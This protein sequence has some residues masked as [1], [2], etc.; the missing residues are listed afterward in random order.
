M[1]KIKSKKYRKKPS[2]LITNT[3]FS[4]QI[5]VIMRHLSFLILLVVSTAIFGQSKKYGSLRDGTTGEPLNGALISCKSNVQ[6]TSDAFGN[7]F[8]SDSDCSEINIT[9]LGYEPISV[10]STRLGADANS[11]SVI[12]LNALPNQLD[13]VTVT[14]SRYE[15]S[16]TQNTISV[17]VIKPALIN[18]INSNSGDAVLNKLPGVQVVGGQANIRGGSGFSYGAGSRV[19]LLIDDMPA[20]QAD[21]GFTNWSDIPIENIGQIEVL[22]GAGS[23]LYGSAALN[24]IVNIRRASPRITPETEAS[25]GYTLFDKFPDPR[26]TWYDFQPYRVNTSLT[27]RRK[28]GK[29]DLTAHGFYNKL[30]SYA[31]ETYENRGRAGLT[32]KY[33][34]SDQWTF[35]LN[36]LLNINHSS[37]FFVWSNAL[38]G[39]LQPYP[40]TVSEGKR[41]RYMIDPFLQY[42]DDRGNQHKLQ[43]RL[44]G[45]NNDNNNNQSNSSLTKYAE[46]QYQKNFDRIGLVLTSGLMGSW[47]SSDAE[48]FGD[49]TFNFQNHAA[50]LQLEK[51]YK[52]WTWT[53]GV[54]YEYNQQ[55][56]PANFQGIEIPGGEI[57]DDQIISR[58]GFNYSL[59]EYTSIRASWGQGYRY[60]TITERFITTNFGGIPINPNPLLKPE[61]GWTAELALKQG[62]KVGLFE[63]FVDIAG[64][65]SVYTDMIEFASSGLIGFMPINVGDTQINGGEISIIGQIKLGK[66]KVQTLAGYTYIDPTYRNFGTNPDVINNLSTDQ[67]VLKYRTR[68]SAKADLEASYKS[69]SLGLSIQKQSHMINIDQRLENPLPGIDLFQLQQ[70]RNQNNSGFTLLDLRLKV[71]VTSFV[72]VSILANNV[73][74]SVYTVRPGLLEAPRNLGIR[75]DFRL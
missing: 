34:L 57:T 26:M 51:T 20:L 54:R 4:H 36:S 58:L 2:L 48:L 69:F 44:Y 13:I 37:D 64:F 7:F 25:I 61:F 45:I 28:I 68:H 38:R 56:S 52:K 70:F 74:N 47:T 12:Y 19:M 59:A 43:M 63:G 3:Y 24:G 75:A 22:K 50:F 35:G 10:L 8:I 14:S 16:L 32:L 65:T 73:L 6:A 21:A 11:A 18:A 41:R 33:H 15:R 67:N 55:S 30:K 29:L 40:G 53:A 72:S 60:P 27:H 42:Q 1:S 49:T 23:A 46:Y 39:I 9:Y 5:W 31:A 71:Q 17:D 62:F 66:V